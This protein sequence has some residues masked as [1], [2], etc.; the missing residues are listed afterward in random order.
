MASTK[1]KKGKK[2]KKKKDGSVASFL[3]LALRGRSSAGGR[4]GG[5][6]CAQR[7]LPTSAPLGKALGA[8]RWAPRG[9]C[10]FPGALPWRGGIGV[11]KRRSARAGSAQGGRLLVPLWGG[12]VLPQTPPASRRG[13]RGVKLS[14]PPEHLLFLGLSRGL[15]QF[16][17][18]RQV[19]AVRY[20]TRPGP[21]PPRRLPCRAGPVAAL[22]L[23]VS[24]AP[25]PCARS[26]SGQLCDL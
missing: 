11:W 1:K 25:L 13:G 15:L 5:C 19:N 9:A 7:L 24:A 20:R 21:A 17:S 3:N 22:P 6:G 10:A 26:A 8:Q 23:N 14:A 4:G 16:C 12:G 18:R 2:R